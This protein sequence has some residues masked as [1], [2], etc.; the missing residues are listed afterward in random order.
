MQERTFNVELPDGRI[1]DGI[2]IGTSKEQIKEKLAAR[3]IAFDKVGEIQEEVR[4]AQ[5][6]DQA[7]TLE[8]IAAGSLKGF[9]NVRGSVGRMVERG[10]NAIGVPIGNYQQLQNQAINKAFDK[11]YGESLTASGAEFITGVGSTLGS[12][13][14]FSKN[15]AALGKMATVADRAIAGAAQ[16]GLTGALLSGGDE[17]VRP[18]SI[19]ALLGGALNV[20]IPGVPAVASQLKKGGKEFMAGIRARNREQLELAAQEMKQRS[21]DLYKIARDS[22]VFLNPTGT[23]R[24]VS[25]VQKAVDSIG[26]N[27]PRLHGDTMAI[28][29]DFKNMTDSGD[30]SLEQ[31]DQVRQLFADVVRKN[32]DAAGKINADAFKANSAISAL[33][34]AIES[35]AP[36]D[37]TGTAKSAL[38]ALKGARAQWRKYRKFETIADIIQKTDGDANRLKSSLQ[39]FVNNK[40]NLRGFSTEEVKALRDAALNTTSEKFLKAIGK[41]G[42]DLGSS[43]TPGNTAIP[44]FSLG[45]LPGGMAL[46]AVGTGARELQKGIARGKAENVLRII[47]KGG[48]ENVERAAKKASK[49]FDSTP[50]QLDSNE[51]LKRLKG[52]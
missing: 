21:G 7:S 17:V 48:E 26:A 31:L 1:I 37:I 42:F 8:S 30:I 39:R 3:G 18:A 6:K 41:F 33:D 51:F 19:D 44:A 5:Q 46:T 14:S 27:H 12:P 50:E 9:Q 29:D 24:L 10:Y 32:T 15:P 11:R 16:G 40:K 4:P 45:I 22:G 20:I 43:L 28:L 23:T 2:P 25:D 34:D 38:D 49:S 36:S 47:D 13:L 52:E 35:L